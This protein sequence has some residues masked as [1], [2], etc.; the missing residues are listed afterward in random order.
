[1]VKLVVAAVL[2]LGS[3]IGHAQ[4]EN[5]TFNIVAKV[6][7]IESNNGIVYYA[8]YDSSER[9]MQRKATQ[10]QM[11]SVENGVA[12]VTFNDVAEGDYSIICFHDI[13]DNKQM[14]FN[15]MGMPL[16]RYGVSNNRINPYGPPTFSDTKFEVKDTNLTFEI[17]LY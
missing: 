9:M 11:S 16:E 8:L 3:L 14:D 12:T 13:N 2:T 4:N 15:E 5:K 1:M 10:S 6:A 17:E 7:N